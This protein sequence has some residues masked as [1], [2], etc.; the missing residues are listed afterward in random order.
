LVCRVVGIGWRSRGLDR[1]EG[2]QIIG[3][4]KGLKI[5][6]GGDGFGGRHCNRAGGDPGTC[7]RPGGENVAGGWSG[8]EGYDGVDGEIE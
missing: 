5:K 6:C 3:N 8:G 4:I 1:V 7:P 2:E